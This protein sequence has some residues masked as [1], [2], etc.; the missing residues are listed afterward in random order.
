MMTY[1]VQ[2]KKLIVKTVGKDCMKVALT[3][4]QKL[5]ELVNKDLG[6]TNVA[7]AT[8]ATEHLGIGTESDTVLVI[9]MQVGQPRLLP[10][11]GV[12]PKFLVGI[13]YALSRCGKVKNVAA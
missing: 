12:K 3:F 10:I 6:S 13:T 9:M 7:V 11:I 1:N 4:R 5:S 2:K 8:N